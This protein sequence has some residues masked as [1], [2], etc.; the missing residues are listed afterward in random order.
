M[1]SLCPEDSS[2]NHGFQGKT[3]RRGKFEDVTM[4]LIFENCVFPQNFHTRKLGEIL[5]F[6]AV[7]SAETFHIEIRPSGRSS[8]YN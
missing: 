1:R 7:S 3:P 4:C 2:Q 5:V 8:K 6:Y